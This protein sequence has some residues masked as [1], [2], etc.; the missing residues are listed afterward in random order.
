MIKTAYTIGKPLIMKM[1]PECAHDLT[2]K[3][4]KSGLFTQSQQP[5]DPR[6]HVTLANMRLSNPLGLAAGF[7]KNADCPDAMLGFGFGFVELGTV[8]PRPQQGNPKPRIFRD[9]ASH[10][11]INRMGFPNGGV[12]LFTK[13]FDRFRQKGKNRSGLIGIN[14]G[15][16]KDT[17]DNAADYLTLIKQLGE[18]ADY[19]T[20]NI[21]SPNTPG[22][23]D[24]QKRENLTPLLQE[25][26]QC[27]DKHAPGTPLFVK[28]AP[29]MD[30]QQMDDIAGTCLNCSVDGVILTNTTLER[31]GHLPETFTS[32]AGGL[33]GPVL[34]D[35]ST[36][37]IARFY[38][39]TSGRLPI[40]GVGGID[41]A[42]R[43]YEK[44]RAGATA[45]QLYTGLVYHGPALANIILQ[46]LVDHLDKDGFTSIEDAIGSGHD[47][48]IAAA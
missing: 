2:L 40:I 30:H 18:R 47:Q 35:L 27:R 4:L 15:K 42:A 5:N 48:Y 13:N 45:L 24:L 23:R 32:E 16:N 12:E 17:E 26:V 9:P 29:D 44:I 28:F 37:V 36:R 6:L 14:I 19:L 38:A 20:V 39:Q 25:F 10:S 41:S 33:S 7:D 34:Q 31:P 11:V 8:T 1:D 21:S 43:A 22:L 46:G 3:S